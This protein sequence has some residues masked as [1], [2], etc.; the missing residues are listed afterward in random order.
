MAK[1]KTAQE[2]LVKSKLYRFVANLFVTIGVVIFCI[3]YVKNVEGKMVEAFQDIKIISIFLVPF[4]PAL[5]LTM[6]ADGAEKKYQ[7]LAEKMAAKPPG[8]APTPQ[9][10]S[11]EKAQVD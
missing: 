2:Y 10:A 11:L 5:V 9:Q 1:E 3:L 4:L 8:K 6:L 7:D